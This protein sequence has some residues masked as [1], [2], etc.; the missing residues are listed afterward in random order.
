MRLETMRERL[1][2]TAKQA[3]PLIPTSVARLAPCL[4]AETSWC[5]GDQGIGGSRQPIVRFTGPALLALA[6]H[7]VGALVRLNERVPKR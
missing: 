3:D 7:L 1:C 4:G 6:L 5:A 2:A